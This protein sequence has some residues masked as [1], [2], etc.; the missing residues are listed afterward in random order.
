MPS[1][2]RAA[3]AG[4]APGAEV[5]PGGDEVFPAVRFALTTCL[6]MLVRFAWRPFGAAVLIQF[7]LAL[8]PAGFVYLQSHGP[9]VAEEHSLTLLLVLLGGMFALSGILGAWSMP[10]TLHATDLMRARLHELF[11][12]AVATW[13]DVRVHEDPALVSKK[14]AARE[15]LDQSAQ[16]AWSFT[17]MLQSFVGLVPMLGLA[18]SVGPWFPVVLVLGM[19][20]STVVQL[21]FDRLLWRVNATYTGVH[22]RIGAVSDVAME[23]AYA[24]DLRTFQMQG[25]A[26]MQWYSDQF[27]LLALFSRL[28]YRAG[29]YLALASLLAASASIVACVLYI[30]PARPATIVLVLGVL[31]N[32]QPLFRGLAG[33]INQLIAFQGPCEALMEFTRAEPPAAAPRAAVRDGSHALEVDR[34]A[35]LYPATEKPVLHDLTGEV[36]YGRMTCIVGPNGAGKSTLVR[37]LTGLYE[38]SGG[39]IRQ[40][41]SITGISVMNQDFAKFPLS[42]RENLACADPALAADDAGLQSMLDRVGL[43]FL[44]EARSANV[45][46]SR[47]ASFTLRSVVMNRSLPKRERGTVDG[48]D[49]YLYIDSDGKGTNLSGG[50]WQRLAI[51]RTLLHGR[52]TRLALFDEPT[53]ALDP[54]AEDELL[55]L[56]Q[57]EMEDHT[58]VLVTHR[59]SHAARADHLLV[60]EEG[61]VTAAGPPREVYRAS[62][63]YREAFDLQAAGYLGVTEG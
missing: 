59:L 35:Y 48:L 46:E 37:I 55:D 51:A 4:E 39:A 6:I 50:Q 12:N 43:G 23:P 54:Y 63:W 3:A 26:P 36:P 8:L 49:S 30:D 2:S 53:S 1:D 27:R 7:V 10:F 33:G 52:R 9:Q 34:I 28:R 16:L 15:A 21:K 13:P 14:T 5:R 38:P 25:W 62:A 40:H 61:R 11:Q 17:S 41:A 57:G 24:K 29:L 22:Q 18:L 56:I 47:A 31:M 60:V 58:L 19:V 45:F 42:V 20:P 44:G 32:I